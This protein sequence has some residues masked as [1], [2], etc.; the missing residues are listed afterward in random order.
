MNKILMAMQARCFGDTPISFLDLDW[1]VKIVQC[2]CQRV[3]EAIIQLCDPF[4]EGIVWQMT[5]VA[6]RDMVMT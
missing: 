4:A 2:E 6:G 1:L 3:K 5:V